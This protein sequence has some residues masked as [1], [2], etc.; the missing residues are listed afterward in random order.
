MINA[1]NTKQEISPVQVKTL[2]WTEVDTEFSA[3]ELAMIF[4]VSLI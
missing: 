4:P 3:D 2:H 1:V